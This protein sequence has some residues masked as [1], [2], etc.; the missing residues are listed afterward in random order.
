MGKVNVTKKRWWSIQGSVTQEANP[1]PTSS[2]TPGLK[3]QT[4]MMN[5]MKPEANPSH[6]REATRLKCGLVE[7]IT[8]TISLIPAAMKGN[9]N[10]RTLSP[11]IHSFTV[12]AP[13]TKPNQESSRNTALEVSIQGHRT[14]WR[15]LEMDLGRQRKEFYAVRLSTLFYRKGDWGFTNFKIHIFFY[16]LISLM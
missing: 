10:P 14:R 7:R 2:P 3:G 16:I 1:L 6:R 13:S 9:T 12:T 5:E 4:W 8:A 11:H 15:R